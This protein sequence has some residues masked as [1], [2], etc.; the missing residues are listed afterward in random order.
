MPPAPSALLLSLALGLPLLPQEASPPAALPRPEARRQA[1][2]ATPGAPEPAPVHC[3]ISAL[4]KHPFQVAGLTV[5]LLDFNDMI[6]VVWAFSAYP[7]P[8]VGGITVQVENPAEAFRV[9]SPS[10]LVILGRD[11]NQAT[12]AWE[13]VRNHRKPPTDTQIVPGGRFTTKYLLSA[14]VQLPAQVFY[15][16]QRLAVVK[17]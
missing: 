9:F 11:G 3:R 13:V 4:N 12:V 8:G 7:T 16:Q 17:D 2:P 15:D 10:K 14:G 5:T 1:T 6:Q